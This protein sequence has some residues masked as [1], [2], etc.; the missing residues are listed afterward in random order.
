M[1]SSGMCLL[2]LAVSFESIV[3]GLGD[4]FLEWIFLLLHFLVSVRGAVLPFLL[5][6]HHLFLF[7][8]LFLLLLLLLLFWLLFLVL[9][10]FLLVFFFLL[11]LIRM[12]AL[13]IFQ[14]LLHVFYTSFHI[15]D[16][17]GDLGHNVVVIV[18]VV[19][20]F[21]FILNFLQN[22]I[23]GGK[24]FERLY[25]KDLWLRRNS[26]VWVRC[27]IGAHAGTT[28]AYLHVAAA[29]RDDWHRNYRLVHISVHRGRVLFYYNALHEAFGGGF[30][31][32]TVQH[33]SLAELDSGRCHALQTRRL[34][35]V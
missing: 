28:L 30:H 16:Q 25:T 26:L 24:H 15:V 2:F 18:A 12:R 20:F 35:A 27:R 10:L 1:M 3:Y 9:F 14:D 13:S 7:L 6:L 8:L 19:L 21:F 31:K 11:L 5:V 23:A 22:S 17:V 32:R 29:T 4:S 33:I 34:D